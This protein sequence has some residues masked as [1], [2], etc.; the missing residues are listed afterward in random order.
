MSCDPCEFEKYMSDTETKSIAGEWLKMIFP[1]GSMPI[2]TGDLDA[3]PHMF[4]SIEFTEEGNAYFVVSETES[5]L[6]YRTGNE[7]TVCG[8]IM[9]PELLNRISRVARS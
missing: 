6:G 3:N 5:E 4:L 2:F 9:S 1:V 7:H 8:F